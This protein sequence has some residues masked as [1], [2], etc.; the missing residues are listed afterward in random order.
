MFEAS[1]LNFNYWH[2]SYYKYFK[3]RLASDEKMNKIE[4]AKRNLELK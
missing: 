2:I 1:K 3:S 4:K